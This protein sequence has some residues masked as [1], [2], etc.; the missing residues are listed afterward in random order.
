MFGKAGISNIIF[1]A[2]VIILI[3]FDFTANTD[4]IDIWGGSLPNKPIVA[5]LEICLDSYA[6][7]EGLVLS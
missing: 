6:S 2:D 1:L 3:C 5:S 4:P 7:W